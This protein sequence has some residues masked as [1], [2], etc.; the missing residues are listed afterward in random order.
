MPVTVAI[1][2]EAALDTD[3]LAYLT[4]PTHAQ[5]GISQLTSRANPSYCLLQY[6]NVIA[7]LFIMG[8][9]FNELG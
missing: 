1:T 3:V 5:W 6:V 4:R 7:T 9:Y 8:N 2:F